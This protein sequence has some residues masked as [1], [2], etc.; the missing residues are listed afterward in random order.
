[1]P[2]G[3]MAEAQRKLLEVGF[4]FNSAC[5]ALLSSFVFRQEATW[6]GWSS[7][8]LSCLELLVEGPLITDPAANDGSRSHGYP[9]G[10]P[11][12]VE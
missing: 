1:M 8:S 3:R 2:N 11:R 12:L 5:P 4:V 10:Q 9:S 6:S 7:S